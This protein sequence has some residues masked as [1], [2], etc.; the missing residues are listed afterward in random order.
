MS[1]LRESARRIAARVM[2][3]TNWDVNYCNDLLL[4]SLLALYDA[5]QDRTYLDFVLG[6]AQKRGWTPDTVVPYRNQPFCCVTYEIYARVRDPRYIKPFVDQTAVY[7]EKVYRTYDG[8]I[9]HYGPEKPDRV[10]ID[11][12]QDYAAR[13]SRAGQ[14]SGDASYFEEAVSQYEIFRAALRNPATGLWAH[15]RGWFSLK[16]VVPTPWLRGHGWLIRG[17]V[18]ALKAMP[19]ESA[20]H[21]RLLKILMEFAADL[22][23]YQREDGMWGQVIDAP[24]SYP[25]TSGTAM[26]ACKFIESMRAGWLPLAQYAGPAEKARHA[27]LKFIDPDGLVRNGCRDTPPLATREEYLTRVCPDDDAHAVAAIIFALAL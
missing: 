12:L 11:Q 25:E 14:L 27:L 6:V 10:L 4:E 20:P 5:T 18:A 1:E 22:V 26:I 17:M 3:R 16:E 13:M 21:R 7:R 19:P 15:G 8:A 23:R 24:E 9:C 2:Q